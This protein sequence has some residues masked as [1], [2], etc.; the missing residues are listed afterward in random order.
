MS[1]QIAPLLFFSKLRQH[2][3]LS[4]SLGYLVGDLSCSFGIHL[5]RDITSGFY[6]F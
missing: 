4:T 5:E 6:N 3:R 1:Q 2:R